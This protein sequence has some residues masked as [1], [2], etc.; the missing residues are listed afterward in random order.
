MRYLV[1]A[2]VHANLPALK[3]VLADAPAWDEVLFLGDAVIGGPQ[4]A[5]TVATLATLPGQFILGNH[6]RE[7]LEF[8]P[9]ASPIS[10]NQA[11]KHWTYRQLSKDDFAVLDRFSPSLSLE[12]D[13]TTYQIQH[14]DF[15]P[16]GIEGFRGRLWPDAAASVFAGLAERCPAQYLLHGHTHVQFEHTRSG[17]TF[18]NP[19]SVGAARLGDPVACYATL[20]EAGVTF[21]A[22]SYDV[23]RTCAAMEEVPID[24]AFIAAWNEQ[25]RDGRQ[26]D[27]YDIRDFTPLC[28]G[29]YR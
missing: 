23:E 1:I 14:G 26:G 9:D 28:A 17:V 18:V 6:D 20:D 12:L 2:D 8:D 13:G 19:G 25:L 16:N 27:F 15:D 10:P 29:P 3:A 21:Y 5:E 7:I 24:S 11:W 4:P 22:T